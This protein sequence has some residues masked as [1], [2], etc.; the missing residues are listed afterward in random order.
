MKLF[1]LLLTSLTI[2]SCDKD[3]PYVYHYDPPKVVVAERSVPIKT[4]AVDGNIDILWVVDNS[5]S[6]YTIQS[7]IVKN[8]KIFMEQFVLQ[9]HINWKMGLISTDEDERPY[10]GFENIFDHTLV[11]LADPSSVDATVATFQDSVRS[12]GTNG[13]ATELTFFNIIQ[14]VKKYDGRTSPP[15]LRP[16]SHLAI[17]MVSDEPEQSEREKGSAYTASSFLNTL[18]TFINTDK[19]LRFYGAFDF[20][21]LQDCSSTSYGDRYAG[22]PFEE[23]INHTAGFHVSACIPDFGTKLVEIGKDIASLVKL[24]SLLL[25]N[26]P[27]VHTLRVFYKGE[28]LLPGASENGGMWYY[29]ARYNSINFYTMDFVQ[30]VETDTFDI[31]YDIDDGITRPDDPIYDK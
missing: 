13:S 6:M 21:D 12:L 20:D 23:A 24:P 2:I 3:S 5:G 7:N 30:N 1:L 18:T 17:I 31:R 22:S 19:T 15:F 10:L 27:K 16:N 8:A 11:D 29:D 25:K 28:E 9:K 4:L 14:V 26:R